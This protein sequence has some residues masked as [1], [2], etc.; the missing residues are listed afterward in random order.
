MSKI[1]G[2]PKDNLIMIHLIMLEPDYCLCMT[3][4]ERERIKSK[5][6]III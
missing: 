1:V 4:H 5:Y 6:L 3:T 2:Y